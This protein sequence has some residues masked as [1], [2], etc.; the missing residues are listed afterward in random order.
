M[1]GPTSYLFNLERKTAQEKQ[2]YSLRDSNGCTIADLVEMRRMAV[3]FYSTL[4]ASDISD[5]QCRKEL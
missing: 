4:Y 5:E 3:N 1:D 2:M